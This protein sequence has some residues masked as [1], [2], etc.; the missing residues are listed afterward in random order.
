MGAGVKHAATGLCSEVGVN[1]VPIRKR[2]K[3]P[4]LLKE[5]LVVLVSVVGL[6]A[7]FAAA[8]VHFDTIEYDTKDS[9]YEH[10]QNEL[11]ARAKAYDENG[12]MAPLEL[13]KLRSGHWQQ[14]CALG[15]FMDPID[16][17]IERGGKVTGADRLR[18]QQKLGGFRIS[19]VEEFEFLFLILEASGR[20]EFIHFSG[21]IG[22]PG[23]HFLKCV[24]K[25]Q[26]VLYFSGE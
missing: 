3:I 9:E 17:A 16:I 15:G 7:I 6:F 14:V 10:W 11:A 2:H 8:L 1:S 13:A 24:E 19:I 20:T 25:P 4:N 12:K 26:T 21:G 22:S 5:L 18:L 23:Q